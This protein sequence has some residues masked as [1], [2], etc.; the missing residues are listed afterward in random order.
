MI[1]GI[2]MG[3]FTYYFKEKLNILVNVILGA[4]IYTGSLYL[5]KGFTKYDINILIK[6]ILKKNHEEKPVG[7][8]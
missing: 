5:I 2:I 8:N 4:I 1:S 7:N 3:V 6:S